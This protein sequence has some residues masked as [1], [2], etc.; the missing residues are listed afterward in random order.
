LVRGIW[1]GDELAAP[2]NNK[3]DGAGLTDYVY[4][5]E[6][7]FVLYAEESIIVSKIRPTNVYDTGIFHSSI[8]LAFYARAR[9]GI[10]PRN[11]VS[12]NSAPLLGWL[13]HG[14]DDIFTT[15]LSISATKARASKRSN[16]LAVSE[17]MQ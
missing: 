4:V 12:G 13:G 1:N 6:A 9:N 15:R 16:G 14:W 7:V 8:V 11:D 2:I 10:L 5:R 3:I 17:E